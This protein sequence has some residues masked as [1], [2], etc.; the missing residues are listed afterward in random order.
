[1]LLLQTTGLS[2]VGKTTLA[3]LVSHQLIAL[4]HSCIVID[5]D[6]YRRTL[7]SDLGFSH[8]D[9]MEN[10]RRLGLL[11]HQHAQ[12]GTVA[13]IA[14]IN[15]FHAARQEL[16]A[17][18]N[19]RTIWIDCPLD[20]LIAR[21]TKGLYQKALLPK[22]H[23]DKLHNLTGVNDVYEKPLDAD[24]YINTHVLMQEEASRLLLDFILAELGPVSVAPADHT[25]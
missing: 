14:A 5:G 15:P 16:A 9:R 10:I 8:A 12:Q 13:I 17:R 21:D 24:L 1:M 19:A 2:G 4:G 3:K 18:Y 20:V 7:C 6:I 11:G 25:A 22:A 23:P